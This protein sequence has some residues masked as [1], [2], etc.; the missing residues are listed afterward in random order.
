MDSP[1]PARLG[2]ATTNPHKVSEIASA[3]EGLPIR[4]LAADAFPGLPEVVEDGATYGENAAKKALS[5][6]RHAGIPALADDSGLEIDALGGAPGI[7]SHRYGGE[8]LPFPEK[9]R[10]ILDALRDTRGAARSARFRCAIALA[11]PDGS[12]HLAEGVSEG[13]IAGAPCGSE[14][15]G[16]DPI[17]LFPPLGRTFAEISAGEKLSVS[18]RGRALARIRPLLAERLTPSAADPRG[19]RGS[20]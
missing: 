9:M 11:L 14:G 19:S 8:G 17:F 12:V 4:L 13:I 5:F 18:H 6:L 1:R 3:L 10:L 15:F 20:P 7:G 16:Y 2:I